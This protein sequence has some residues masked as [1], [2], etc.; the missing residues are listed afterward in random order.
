[1]A[2]ASLAA[3][4]RVDA[5]PVVV[6]EADSGACRQ[7]VGEAA[8]AARPEGV[9]VLVAVRRPAGWAGPVCQRLD[10]LAGPVVRLRAC[11]D[12]PVARCLGDRVGL[13]CRVLVSGWVFPC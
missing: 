1:M 11:S 2:D 10:G 7:S 13:A 6:P 12:A 4:G 8:A 3:G 5:S 9:A